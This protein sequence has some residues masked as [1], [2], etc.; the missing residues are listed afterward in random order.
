MNKHFHHLSFYLRY[1][2]W[3]QPVTCFKFD[4]TS[5]CR[6]LLW[7]SAIS[8]HLCLFCSFHLR[9][10]ST[11]SSTPCCTW[12]LFTFSGK[13]VSCRSRCPH[14]HN[15]HGSMRSSVKLWL[16][17]VGVQPG[18]LF[19]PLSLSQYK[20]II[21]K[22]LYSSVHLQLFTNVTRYPFWLFFALL[23][24]RTSCCF[25]VKFEDGNDGVLEN[26]SQSVNLSI[27]MQE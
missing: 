2:N 14:S 24:P 3:L 6:G 10:R 21:N 15:Q 13:E 5:V 22:Q 1:C 26:P 23:L 9:R 12:Y 18:H 17:T 25:K 7:L 19:S 27:C 16:D 8:P 4:Q 20:C 11:T